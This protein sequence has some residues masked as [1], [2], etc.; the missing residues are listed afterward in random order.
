MNLTPRRF[1][2]DKEPWYQFKWRLNGLSEE[3][4]MFWTREKSLAAVR[5]QISETQFFCHPV[6]SKDI[7]PTATF[8]LLE[9]QEHRE[10]CDKYLK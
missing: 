2:P 10:N 1:T 6:R 4:W 8:R 7:T 9:P 3:D 5:I